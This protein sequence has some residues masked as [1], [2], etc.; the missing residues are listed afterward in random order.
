MTPRNCASLIAMLFVTLIAVGNYGCGSTPPPHPISVSVSPTSATVQAG[1]TVQLTT[2]L[3]YDFDGKG[4]TWTVSCSATSCG[5]VSPSATGAGTATTYTAPSTPPASG[6]SVTVKATSV[7]DQ[8][9]SASATITVP[10]NTV[11]VVPATA[12]VEA[13]ATAKFTATVGNDPS[14]TGVT[15]TVSCSSAPCGTVSPSSTPSGTATIYTAPSTRPASDLTVTLTATSVA[16]PMSFASAAIDVPTITVSVVPASATVEAG[17]TAQFTTTVGNDPSNNGVTWTVSCSATSC[18]SVSPTATSSGTATTYTAPSTAP[19]SSL[20]VDLTATSMAD[21]TKLGSATITVPAIGVSVAPSSALLPV[22][23]T[24]Q[25]TATVTF[26]S[27]NKGVTWTLTQNGATC[28]SACGAVSPTPTASGAPTTY[29]APATVP[30]PA[31]VTL[32]A[33]SVT[34]TTKSAGATITISSGTVKIVPNILNFGTKRVNSGNSPPQ[35]ATLT[36][37]GNSALSITNITITGTDLANFSQSNTCATSV[38]AGNACALS[39]TFNPTANGLR[40]ANVS[41][42]DNSADSP[43]QISL[44]G[45]GSTRSAANSLAVRSTL[46]QE[47]TTDAPLPVGPDKVGTRTMDLVDATR[48]DP[49]LAN[50]S[51]RELLV[52]FWYPAF[53]KQGCQHAQY[54]SPKVWNYFSKLV[55]VPLPEVTTNSCWNAPIA[56]GDHPIVVFT[57]GYTGTFT[58]YT[59]LFEDLASRGYVVASVDHTYEATAVEFPDGRLAES[60]LGSHLG[61]TWRGDDQTL[62]FATSVRLDDLRFVMDKLQRLNIQADSPFASKLDMSHVAVA[63]HSIGG[64]TAFL[65]IEQEPR[66][67]AGIVIDGFVPA[68]LIKATHTPVLILAAGREKWSSDECRLWS[69]LRGARLAVNLRGTEHVA[70]SD[71]IWLAK[72][73]IETGSMGPEKTMAAARDYV[74]AFLDANLLG[75]PTDPLLTGPSS[76]YPD[77]EVT[78]QNESLRRKP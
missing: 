19:A 5:G 14:N 32:M 65:S 58:D 31:T 60:V 34:D 55:G 69:N 50:G 66:F 45:T 8:M 22:N 54:A 75:K 28:S 3:L 48:D 52:Q 39:V 21:S 56:D 17:T 72:D 57:P 51:K 23:I 74:A 38:G 1:A 62:A 4:V 35:T 49:Y 73:A 12:T 63:G 71:W 59:F 24:Q 33:T 25:F 41:I 27:S 6:L 46:T 16:D 40:T 47:G 70:L 13:G 76:E 78:T 36:N 44:T 9:A 26:D 77:A 64:A 29:T 15:W 68:A 67:Q 10:G 2:T 53:L 37:T 20:T 18:G 7:A 42:S 61:N 11:S 43:Q 30:S